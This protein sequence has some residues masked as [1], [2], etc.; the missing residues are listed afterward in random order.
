MFYCFIVLLFLLFY[1]FIVL[2]FYCFIVLLFFIKITS[3]KRTADRINNS[4]TGLRPWKTCCSRLIKVNQYNIWLSINCTLYRESC[5][6]YSTASLASLTT[7]NFITVQS[8]RWKLNI[9][10]FLQTVLS[11]HPLLRRRL[12]RSR[13]CP[14]NGGFTVLWLLLG[15]IRD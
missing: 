4:S 1:C 9:A 15:V 12:G 13:R 3:I 5:T 11:G 7:W 6:T 8:N 14:L 2:L 10:Q